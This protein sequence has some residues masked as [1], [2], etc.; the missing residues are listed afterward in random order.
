MARKLNISADRYGFLSEAHIKLRPVEGLTSGVYLAGSAQWPRDLPDTATSASA[1]ASKVLSLF[2]RREL[3]HEPTVAVVD[4]ETCTGCEQCVAVCA[5][6]AISMDPRRKMAHVNEAL[7]EGCGAC[8]VVCP[9]KAMQ[10][11]N[12]THRQFFEMIDVAAG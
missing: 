4:E 11:K 3:L 9:P 7:C 12:W 10:H 5:Y 2:A 6:R 1:A 8:V